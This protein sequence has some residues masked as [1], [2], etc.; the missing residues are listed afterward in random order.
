[1]KIRLKNR[2]GCDAGLPVGESEEIETI[3]IKMAYGLAIT[4]TPR[5]IA[6]KDKT[7]KI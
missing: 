6:P 3:E 5:D 4:I 2:L 1:M 7:E